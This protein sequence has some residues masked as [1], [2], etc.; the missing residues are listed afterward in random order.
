MAF[1]GLYHR[2]KF[3]RNR[4]SSF[5]DMQGLLFRDLGLKMPI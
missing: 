5:D 1:G 4:C 2:A 3:G